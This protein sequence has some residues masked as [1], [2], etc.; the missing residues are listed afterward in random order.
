MN[1]KRER[2][3]ILSIMILVIQVLALAG[4]NISTSFISTAPE[5]EPL[6]LSEAIVKDYNLQVLEYV[7]LPLTGYAPASLT[8]SPADAQGIILYARNS[9]TYYHPVQIAQHLLVFLDNYR[10]MGAA[11]YLSAA[12]T[13]AAKLLELAITEN[14]AMYFP[15]PF[16]FELHGSSGDTMRAPW[17]SGM[18]Q[19][20]ALSCFVRLYQETA[21]SA[22][23]VAAKAVLQSFYLVEGEA[24]PWTAS[25]DPNGYYWIDEYPLPKNTFTLNGHIFA[26]IGLYE[27][28]LT[29]PSPEL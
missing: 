3:W 4:C 22:Y 20:Q 12:E 11:A 8:V 29:Q 9:L 24:E 25:V 5:G 26:I 6:P 28:W 18:A 21:D 27:L 17:Y 2:G 15:Y 23:L 1:G 14:G 10:S 13:Y 16:D 7:E 19:G